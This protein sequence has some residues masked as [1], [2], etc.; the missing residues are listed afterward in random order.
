MENVVPIEQLDDFVRE[1]VMQVNA[2]LAAVRADGVL[3]EMPQSIQITAVV[4][5]EWQPESLEILGERE[6]NESGRQGG[7]T[8]E[9][10]SGGETQSQTG[11]D[12]STRVDRGTNT[13]KQTTDVDTT[14]II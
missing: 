2:G 11:N 10:Q 9:T 7:T 5:K 13:H 14:F 12:Q 3:V 4:V 6:T 1:M 8:S